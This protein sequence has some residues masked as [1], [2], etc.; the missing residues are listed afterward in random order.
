MDPYPY[1]PETRARLL[2]EADAV[3]AAIR[4]A[5]NEALRMHKRMGNPIASWANGQVVW[6]PPDQIPVDDVTNEE[7]RQVN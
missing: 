4:E 2:A 5:V 6:I 1:D 7:A 3:E